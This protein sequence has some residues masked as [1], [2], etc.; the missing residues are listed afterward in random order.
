M[1]FLTKSPLDPAR[2]NREDDRRELSEELDAEPPSTESRPGKEG[3]VLASAGA[4]DR[5]SNLRGRAA[6]RLRT[7]DRLSGADGA[8]N[9]R[10]FTIR[11]SS[12]YKI[13]LSSYK[14]VT[15]RT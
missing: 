1:G 7:Q 11:L 4:G 6:K 8:M 12:V 2:D 14:K 5:S 9:R 13:I 15:E 3:V 10:T